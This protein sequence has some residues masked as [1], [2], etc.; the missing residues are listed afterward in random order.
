MLGATGNVL[1][2]N[3]KNH[4]D[5]IAIFGELAGSSVW[6]GFSIGLSHF[7]TNN[8]L[9]FVEISNRDGDWE[10]LCS[11]QRIRRIIVHKRCDICKVMTRPNIVCRVA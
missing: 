8:D 11:D 3:G 7:Q 10:D 5:S 1:E 4:T 6:H 2:I 9:V